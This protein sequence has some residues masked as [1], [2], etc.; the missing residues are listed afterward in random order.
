MPAFASPLLPRLPAL[1]CALALAVSGCAASGAGGKAGLEGSSASA[2]PPPF[3]VPRPQRISPATPGQ[4]AIAATGDSGPATPGQ[5]SIAATDDNGPATPGQKTPDSAPYAEGQLVLPDG[6]PLADADFASF[7]SGAGYILAGENH[8]NPAHHLVQARLLGLLAQ[9][10]RRPMLGLEMVPAR[11]QATLDRFNAGRLSLK[12]LPEALNWRETWGFDFALYRPVFEAARREHSPVYGLNVPRSLIEA[13]RRAGGSDPGAFDLP[14]EGLSRTI[15]SGAL[16]ALPAGE[17]RFLPTLILPPPEEQ[18]R[19]LLRVFSAHTGMA[20]GTPGRENSAPG[21]AA[22]SR[23]A[24]PP[25]NALPAAPETPGKTAMRE[26]PDKTAIPE[27]STDP[28]FRPDA[29]ASKK[30]AAAPLSPERF[31]FI[32]S[33]WDSAMAEN[34]AKARQRTGRPMLILAGGGHVESGWGIARRLRVFDPGAKILL[35]MPFSGSAPPD[36]GAADLF[37]YAKE[38]SRPRLGIAFALRDGKMR[39][40]GVLPGSAAEKAGLRPG[41]IIEEANGTHVSSPARLHAAAQTLRQGKALTLTILRNGERL[42][43]TL[44]PAGTPEGLRPSGSPQGA[45]APL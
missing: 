18:S 11:L 14:E 45:A 38:R 25:E 39:V 12:A 22:G 24:L 3:S 44:E 31:L 29:P 9:A 41:D 17:K 19:R 21:G 30:T 7:A 8:D 36:P 37:F 34:A 35:V 10:G 27:R 26:T 16:A 32:Q 5:N 15:L 23:P 4:N 33:L 13:L 40:E 42:E 2:G 20:P 6:R 28:L 43:I 1:L